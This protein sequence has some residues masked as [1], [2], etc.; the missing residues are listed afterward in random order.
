MTVRNAPLGKTSEMTV[1]NTPL[2]KTSAVTVRNAPAPSLPAGPQ[3][4]CLLCGKPRPL[5]D[6]PRSA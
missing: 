1:H 5:A 2:G 6:P 3:P 4:A